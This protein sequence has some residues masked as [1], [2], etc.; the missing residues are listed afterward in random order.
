M[1][2]TNLI[3]FKVNKRPYLDDHAMR[4]ALDVLGRGSEI[5]KD[6]VSG[7]GDVVAKHEILGEGL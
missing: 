5:G 2:T 4:N 6:L 3:F 1:P 7:R